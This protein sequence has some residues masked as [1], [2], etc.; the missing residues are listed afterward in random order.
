MT[1]STESKLD[2]NRYIG[3]SMEL[4]KESLRYLTS[5]ANS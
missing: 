5:S 3:T 1:V 4:V 2:L